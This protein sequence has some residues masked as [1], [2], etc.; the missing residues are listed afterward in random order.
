MRSLQPEGFVAPANY[1]SD[2]LVEFVEKG[3]NLN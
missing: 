1:L 2:V 3:W